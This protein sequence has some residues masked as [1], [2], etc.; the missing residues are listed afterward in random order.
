MIDMGGEAYQAD[1]QRRLNIPKA[2]LWRAI[3]RLENSGYVQVI[4]E[5]RVNKIKL[6]K[7]PKLD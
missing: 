5:G 2:T 1:L 4:K 7:K 3:R 6:V